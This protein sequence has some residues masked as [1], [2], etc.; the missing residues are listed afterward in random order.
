MTPNK[1]EVL[2]LELWN[3]S[4]CGYVYSPRLGN[5][6]QGVLPGLDFSE[7]PDG[8]RCPVCGKDKDT[9]GLFNQ[10]TL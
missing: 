1:K 9:F 10:S 2:P 7:I 4:Y 5:P 3:C 6:S 8:W